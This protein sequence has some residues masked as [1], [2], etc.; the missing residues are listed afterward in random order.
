VWVVR[1]GGG[2]PAGDDWRCGA[3]CVCVCLCVCVWCVRAL[4]NR[5]MP[6]ARPRRGSLSSPWRARAQHTGRACALACRWLA[7]V[8]AKG[9]V[10]AMDYLGAVAS[11]QQTTVDRLR[12]AVARLV[13]SPVP[14]PTRLRWMAAYAAWSAA[15]MTACAAWSAAWRAACM[16]ACAAGVLR[17]QQLPRIKPRHE[18]RLQPCG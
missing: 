6:P 1:A 9:V 15:W 17:G 18:R 3:V 14:L 11:L 10:D 5:G 13:R 2:K 4:K 12:G 8:P 7:G 16:T